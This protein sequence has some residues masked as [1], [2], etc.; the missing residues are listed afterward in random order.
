MPEAESPQGRRDT[1]QNGGW[2]NTYR[3][4]KRPQ[5]ELVFLK[6]KTPLPDNSCGSMRE[7]CNRHD[8]FRQMQ[9]DSL[10]TRTKR[11]FILFSL[12]KASLAMSWTS[13]SLLLAYLLK[14]GW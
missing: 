12:A 3:F 6:S 7:V 10:P 14:I 9:Q 11:Y 4:E 1:A 5:V 2:L 13:K 8:Q